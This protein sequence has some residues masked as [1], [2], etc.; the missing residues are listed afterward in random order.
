MTTEL[1][2][3][4]IVG[5]GLSDLAAG[6][7]TVPALLVAIARPRLLRLG[8]DVP[9]PGWADAELRLYRLLRV[10]SPRDAYTRYNSLIRRLISYAHALE[11]EH[12]RRMRRAA[13]IRIE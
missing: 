8:L 1:P 10:Q 7:E 9:D 13:S 5:Q 3:A 12:G 2:G 11:A 4:E 6:A